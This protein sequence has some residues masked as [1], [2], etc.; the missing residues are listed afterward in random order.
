MTIEEANE[1][2]RNAKPI[3]KHIPSTRTVDI[4]QP[5]QIIPDKLNTLTDIWKKRKNKV[6][7]RNLVSS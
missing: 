5:I 7:A 6:A 2:I 1:I 3:I 4:S